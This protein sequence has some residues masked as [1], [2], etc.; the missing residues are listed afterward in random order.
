MVSVCLPCDALWQYLLS[1]LGFS[2]LGRGVSLHGCFSKAQPLFL[3]LDERYHLTATPPDLENGVAPLEIQEEFLSAFS[4]QVN[5]NWNQSSKI[6]HS[7]SQIRRLNVG[8]ESI[9]WC[10]QIGSVYFW[11]FPIKLNMKLPYGIEFLFLVVSPTEI[12][13]SL[14]KLLYKSVSFISI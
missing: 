4:W 7:N 12:M 3:T 1:Y 13:I 10:N 5:A 11:Q 6:M 14:W 8:N 2:S 9:N